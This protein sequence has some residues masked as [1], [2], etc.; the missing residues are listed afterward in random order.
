MI[1]LSEKAKSILEYADVRVYLIEPSNS[2][3]QWKINAVSEFAE[4]AGEGDGG[5]WIRDITFEDAFK[6]AKDSASNPVWICSGGPGECSC[7]NRLTHT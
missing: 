1:K 2:N 6:I 4:Q 7:I 3:Q 5:C